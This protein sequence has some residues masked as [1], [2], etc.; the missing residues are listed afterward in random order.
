MGGFLSILCALEIPVV[1]ATVGS[2]LNV[3]MMPVL[4][5]LDVLAD[6]EEEEEY[7][8]R[9]KTD[10]QDQVTESCA[11]HVYPHQQYRHRHYHHK[12][13]TQSYIDFSATPSLS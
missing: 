10:A 11:A 8:L 13:S 3:M 5:Q 12:Y 1:V 9:P 2:T 6:V 7:V 4:V